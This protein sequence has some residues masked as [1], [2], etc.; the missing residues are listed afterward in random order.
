M[1]SGAAASASPGAVDDPLGDGGGAAREGLERLFSVSVCLDKGSTADHRRWEAMVLFGAGLTLLPLSGRDS[2]PV[3][4]AQG[5][6]LSFQ[7]CSG[8][9]FQDPTPPRFTA[10]PCVRGEGAVLRHRCPGCFWWFQSVLVTL[11]A[12]ETPPMPFTHS[13]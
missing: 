2:A 7:A 12:L 3:V 9:G 11:T 10:D 1:W 6:L 5:C 13:F 4:M 8:V